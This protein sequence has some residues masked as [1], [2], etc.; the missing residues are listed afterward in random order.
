[1]KKPRIEYTLAF[2]SFWKF[3]LDTLGH[4]KVGGKQAA[5]RAWVE[6]GLE[7]RPGDATR[8]MR[9]M[10]DVNYKLNRKYTPHVSTWINSGA[11]DNELPSMEEQRKKQIA[12]YEKMIE[13]KK[14]ER[15]KTESLQKKMADE[16]DSA[17]QWASQY[18]DQQ[19]SSMHKKLCIQWKIPSRDHALV[20]ENRFKLGLVYG[21]YKEKQTFK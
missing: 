5:M 15:E 6:H 21:F 8:A 11:Y 10:Y 3:C 13:T 1:M 19:L 2:E 12:L 18:S 17:L 14:A 9:Y 20:R 4:D 7:G 16:Y